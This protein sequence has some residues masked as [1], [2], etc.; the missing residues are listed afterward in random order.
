MK[1]SLLTFIFISLLL[2]GTV[3]FSVKAQSST[4]AD[5]MNTIINANSWSPT[6]GY[7]EVPHFAM[8]FGKGQNSYYQAAA[9]LASSGT[10]PVYV[11]R[12]KRLAELDGVSG[13][14]LDS[15]VQNYLSSCQML[16]YVPFTWSY[17]GQWYCIYHREAAHGYR[18]A[19][20]NLQ[21]KWNP[22]AAI[23]QIDSILRNH[24]TLGTHIAYNL[25][26]GFDTYF[27]YYDDTAQTIAWLLQMGGTSAISACD[28]I[29]NFQ[30]D[31]FWNGQYYGYDGKSRMETEVG[32]FALVSGRY[33]MTKGT[34]NQYGQRIVSDLNAKLLVNGYSSPLWNHYS[35]NHVPGYDERRLENAV[36]AWGALHAYYP[37]MTSTMQTTLQGMCG[38]GWR[39]LLAESGNFDPATNMF[40]IW[41][42]RSPDMYATGVGLMY[43]FLNG[44]VP[45]T[46]SL[47]IPLNDESYEETA[48]W[49]PATMF[50]FDYNNRQIRIPVN[51]GQ[52]DFLFGSGRASYTFPS[53]GVYTVTFSNDWNTVVSANSIGSLD[54][55][56]KYIPSGST[57]P[58]SSGSI[59]ASADVSCTGYIS[60]STYTSQA[61]SLPHTWPFVQVGSY[62][63]HATFSDGTEQ[64]KSVTV[65]KDQ[66]AS[67]VF[68]YGE[69]PNPFQFLIDF[70]LWLAAW[71]HISPQI[72]FFG[73][74]GLVVGVG[75]IVG[76]KFRKAKYFSHR[77]H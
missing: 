53:T 76:W 54:S 47:A 12:V 46:G 62:T 75:G 67:V 33:L 65:S 7:G 31:Y 35:L 77:R 19:S 13:A 72:M 41:E 1:R 5:T 71:F 9:D 38:V 55:Q 52:L 25:S 11:L 37:Q 66:T 20:S 17:S 16:G 36:A 63:V 6:N 68:T 64:T 45:K 23:S 2:I 30:Q 15:T 21:S 28:L 43:L 27:R 74:I 61:Y 69:Q 60:N 58:P 56:F 10:Y 73:V 32:P 29:W 42:T 57:P 26:T 8:V 22:T 49:S 70:F 3:P 40:R 48:A 14:V 44:I 50:R 34:F 51:A 59:S 39:G 24:G 18:W 4:L